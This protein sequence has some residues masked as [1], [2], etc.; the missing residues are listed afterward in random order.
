[1]NIKLVHHF[2]VVN[3]KGYLSET[4]LPNFTGAIKRSILADY[5]GLEIAAYDAQTICWDVYGQVFLL[6]F[7]RGVSIKARLLHW[8]EWNI[9]CVSF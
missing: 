9:R 6:S 4:Y 2:F 7:L 1:M 5:Y 3:Q 8:I